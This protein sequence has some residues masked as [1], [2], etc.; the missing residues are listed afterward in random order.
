MRDKARG[1]KIVKTRWDQSK[2]VKTLVE[3]R[4]K[5]VGAHL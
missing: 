5:V 1:E 2:G 3:S 4:L